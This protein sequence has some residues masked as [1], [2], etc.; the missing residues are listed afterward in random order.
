MKKPKLANAN[1]WYV[2]NT[3]YGEQEGHTGWDI[4]RQNQNREVWN[5]WRCQHLSEKERERL[6][7]GGAEVPTREDWD[8]KAGDIARLHK[9][10]MEERNEGGFVYPGLPDPTK[11]VDLSGITFL[12]KVSFEKAIFNVAVSFD[13]SI[14]IGIASFYRTKFNAVANFAL[15]EFKAKA[16]FGLAVFD[17]HAQFMCVKFGDTS[18]FSSTCFGADSSFN[19]INFNG[20][21]SFESSKFVG[22][23]NFSESNFISIAVF[24]RAAF[25]ANSAFNYTKFS[26][27]VSFNSAAFQN[28]ATFVAAN[29]SKD[30]D[31]MSAS[32]ERNVDFSSAQFERRISLKSATFLG[33]ASFS[34]VT[35]GSDEWGRL[36]VLD[37]TDVQFDKP[38]SFSKSLFLYRY[39]IFTGAIIDD[40]TV[41]STEEENWP[42]KI[43]RDARVG[44]SSC[45]Y[46]RHHFGK[47]GLPEDELFFF[48]REMEFAGQIGNWADS[49]PYRFYG[50]A[51]DYGSSIVKPCYALL[52]I[53]LVPALIYLGAFMRAEAHGG[54]DY[55]PMEAIGF[56]FSNIFKFFGLQGVYF[57]DTLESFE[58]MGAL[59]SVLETLAATQTVLGFTALFFL[60]LGLRQRFRLR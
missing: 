59:G 6:R 47:Q 42:S 29:F 52:A 5:L 45:A 48:K 14:F 30:V 21:A 54:R 16:D 55:G 11:S 23:A 57:D 50:W 39:P 34:E 43:D 36:C 60:G 49:A 18:S 46:L 27:E 33:R 15:A 9:Q 12:K 37:L 13:N 17:A 28:F 2:L 25:I 31:F 3:L 20:K 44:R 41:F 8:A 38:A 1:P 19:E 32:F 56:S 53:W 40:K 24:D 51:S 4:R 7:T 35:F 58:K 22:Y 26:D 10:V